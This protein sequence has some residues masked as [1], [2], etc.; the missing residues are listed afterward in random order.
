MTTLK[1]YEEPATKLNSPLFI[2]TTSHTGNQDILRNQ[3]KIK[4][5]IVQVQSFSDVST[6]VNT[7]P[8][9]SDQQLRLQAHARAIA[10][11]YL[12][13][14]KQSI[15]GKDHIPYS[16]YTTPPS[17]KSTPYGSHKW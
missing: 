9:S 8:S 14:K 12:L 1:H 6:D 10:H 5:E 7:L 17:N 2:P 4:R 11:Q 13:Q 16:P 3:S 15:V